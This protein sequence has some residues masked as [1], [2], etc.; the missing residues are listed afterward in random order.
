MAKTR[1]FENNNVIVD[2]TEELVLLPNKHGTVQQLGLFQTEG[3]SE[4]VVQFEETTVA[5]GVMVDVVRGQRGTVGT[6][7]TSK[8]RAWAIPHFKHS[9]AIFPG[10]VKAKRAYGSADQEDPLAAALS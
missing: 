3:V 5:D 9:D 8:V 6:D 1:S 7:R 2:W 10:D 4:Q